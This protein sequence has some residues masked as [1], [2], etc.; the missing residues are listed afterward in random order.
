MKPSELRLFQE[1]VKSFHVVSV[2]LRC[3]RNTRSYRLIASVI[4][5]L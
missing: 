4:L 3:I 1:R 2:A 5:G